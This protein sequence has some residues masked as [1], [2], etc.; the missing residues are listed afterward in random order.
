MAK[1][2][3][4]Q[5]KKKASRRKV[6]PVIVEIV[7]NGVIA[8][9]EEMKTNLMRTAYNMI[10]YEALDFTTGLFTPE[11]ETV[12]IGIGLPMLHPR[13][14]GDREGEDQAFRHQEHQAGRHLRHQRFLH[15]RQPSQPFHLHPADLPQGQARRLLLLH[16]A[17]ARRRRRARRHDHRHLFRRHADPDPEVPGPRQGQPGPGR[18]HPHERA[19]AAARHGRPA[20]ADHRGEDRRAALPRTARPLRPRRGDGVDRRDH[21]PRRGRGARAHPDHS[22]RRLRGGVL[23]RRRRHRDRQAHPGQGQGHRQG[24]RDD[25][26][27]DRRVEAGARLLQL[28][29]HHRLRLR[30]GRLQVHHLA[31]RLSDQRRRVPQPQG[32]HPAGPHRQRGAAGADALVDDLPDDHRRH[33]L[34]GAAAGDPR[35]RHRRPSRRSRGA[36]LPRLQSE[37][38][39]A[40]HR[41]LRPAR[42]RLGRQED[43]GRR[44]GDGVPERRR[45][46][47]R[48][49]RAGR[50][51]IP[52]HGGALRA[53]SGFRRRRPP[54]RRP[55]H[56]ADHARA[57]P[58]S[59]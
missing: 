26:R 55:G 5:A 2:A 37:D 13:H 59:R 18:H 15:H 17:L 52:D 45:H 31:D 34:Q 58:T 9:T 43:R 48:P 27:P 42:R 39:G 28:G 16:G 29:D 10:I 46:P 11:G 38:L 50:G 44:V 33:D 54:S 32:H 25:H 7:R 22:R 36:E 23:A 53:H 30:A 1:K 49:E 24:R 12:S 40:V 57:A 20:R 8:V 3:I 19:P 47:Q 4:K 35:P 56:R 6:D 51:E 14:G 21:G 41:H